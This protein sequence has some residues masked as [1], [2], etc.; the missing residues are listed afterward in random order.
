MNKTETELRREAIYRRWG[1]GLIIAGVSFSLIAGVV[2]KALQLANLSE[3]TKNI[4]E[5]KT[6][7][8]V[9][10]Y[11]TILFLSGLIMII[12]KPLSRIF[13]KEKA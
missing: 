2:D 7:W 8:F 11:G 3:C 6:N 13:A 4:Y 5:I 1:V 12:Y 10:G 9:V